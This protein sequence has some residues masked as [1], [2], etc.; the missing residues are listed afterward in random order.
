MS[1]ISQ[2]SD[3]DT[4]KGKTIE[5]GLAITFILNKDRADKLYQIIKK[6]DYFTVG[7]AIAALIDK[8]TT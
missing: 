2:V 1:V 3:N 5:Y 7:T 8:E 4:S 6:N